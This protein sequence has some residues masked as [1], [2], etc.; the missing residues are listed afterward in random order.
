MID[1]NAMHPFVI[2]K[3]V[4]GSRFTSQMTEAEKEIW[5]AHEKC[6]NKLLNE[7]FENSRLREENLR[8]KQENEFMVRLINERDQ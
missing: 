4:L 6:Y 1:T 2:W 8:L 7:F 5:V 3:K